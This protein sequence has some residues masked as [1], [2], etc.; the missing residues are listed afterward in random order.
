[1]ITTEE[2]RAIPG[3]EGAYEVSDQ[4]RVRSLE[5]LNA[6]GRR[7]QAKMLS[8]RRTTRDHLAVAM[9]SDAQRA[10]F[11]VHAL[12]LMV[13]V[14]P[15]PDGLEGCHRNDD[16]SDNRLTNLRWDTRSSNV[17]DSVRN[18]THYMARRT[19]CP[20]GHPYTAEN[21]YQYPKGNRAC[22]E[23]RTRARQQRHAARKAA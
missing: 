3:Y 17:L 12:V 8:P 23:C 1:V 5:R 16:P 4:G 22:R 6:R 15:C 9:Y 19:H 10:D 18:G 21:T 2:W 7:Q 11:Q 14:G 13:F 20:S